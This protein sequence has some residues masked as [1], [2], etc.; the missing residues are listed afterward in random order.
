M[1]GCAC[2]WRVTAVVSMMK[3]ATRFENVI[4]MYVSILMRWRWAL[5]LLGRLEQRLL[6]FGSALL[7][8]FLRSLPE[9]TGYGLIVVPNTATSVSR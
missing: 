3:N 7:F 9:K 4:P 8:H 5:G 1:S 6:A 2:A